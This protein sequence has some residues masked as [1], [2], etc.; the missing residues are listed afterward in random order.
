M[1]TQQKKKIAEASDQ[2]LREFAE[3][4]LQLDLSAVGDRGSLLAKLAP[5]WP[6]DYIFVDAAVLEAPAEEQT[7][8]V[9]AQARTQLGG[10]KYESDPQWLIRINATELPGGKEPVPLGHNGDHLVVQRNTEVQV[11]HRFIGILRDAVRVSITQ[12]PRTQEFSRSNFTN[13]PFEVLDKPS[14]SEIEAFRERT[15]DLVLA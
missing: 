6:A 3:L 11:P 8:D 12:D 14:R 7:D 9:R 5:A 2:E 4:T 15:K 1:S 13:Y 10:K